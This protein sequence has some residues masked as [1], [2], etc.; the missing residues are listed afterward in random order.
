ML[1]S[2]VE[3]ADHVAAVVSAFHDRAWQMP[4]DDVSVVADLDPR[5]FKG[6]D[7]ADV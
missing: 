3:Q 5:S 2:S 4:D 1:F 7:L 6:L